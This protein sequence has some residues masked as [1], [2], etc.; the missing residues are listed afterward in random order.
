MW[1]DSEAKQPP[2]RIEVGEELE[3]LSIAELEQRVEILA[4]EIARVKE[5]ITQKQ[6]S[7]SAAMAV[8]KK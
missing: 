5:K 4:G 3:R 2:K 7:A 6:S 1:D 8:F